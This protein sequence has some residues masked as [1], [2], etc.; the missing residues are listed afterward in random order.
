MADVLDEGGAD[1]SADF[2]SGQFHAE[3]LGGKGKWGKEK[4]G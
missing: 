2:R 4:T 1:G 3:T